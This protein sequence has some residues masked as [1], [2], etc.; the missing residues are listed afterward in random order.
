MKRTLVSVIILVVAFF[1][2]MLVGAWA[3]DEVVSLETGTGVEYMMYSL[4][5][6]I[7]SLCAA[8]FFA[9][10]RR[11]CIMFIVFAVIPPLFAGITDFLVA[12]IFS[13]IIAATTDECILTWFRG[14]AEPDKGCTLDE[15]DE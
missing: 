8:C 11:R 14:I 4:L 9:S 13:G 15:T 1:A 10:D 2:I 6:V 5:S 7:L 3:N 12:G